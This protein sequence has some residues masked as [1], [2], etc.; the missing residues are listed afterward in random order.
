MFLSGLSNDQLNA[1]GTKIEMRN[2]VSQPKQNTLGTVINGL[3]N[4][5]LARNTQPETLSQEDYT[6]WKSGLNAQDYQTALTPE[7]TK[8]FSDW[9]Y[10][11][12][13]PI[14]NDY[15][16]QGYWK[17]EVA[18]YDALATQGYTPE[19]IAGAKQG[20][21]GGDAILAKFIQEQGIK[22]PTTPSE[23]ALAKQGK[24]N[25]PVYDETTQHYTDKYK[26]P[27]HETFSNESM[28]ATGD[29]AKYAGK[30]EGD[31]F[32]TPYK[33]KVNTVKE[34][35]AQIQ[36][37]YEGN[38]TS[39]GWN[40]V[41]KGADV[42]RAILSNPALQGAVAGLAYGKYKG[43]AMEGLK[44]GVDFASNK[45]TSNYYAKML[46][47]KPGILGNYG[48]N[49]YKAKVTADYNTQRNAIY[50]QNVI[51]QINHRLVQE[52]ISWKELERKLKQDEFD[53]ELAL[54]K[55]G[56]SVAQLQEAIRYHNGMLSQRQNRLKLDKE[57]FEYNK[58]NKGK[59][60][61]SQVALQEK[62]WAIQDSD[63]DEDEKTERINDLINIQALENEGEDPA[64][65]LWD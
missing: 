14:S 7:E 19:Q 49:D 17:N 58:K 16:M 60:P 43:D 31:N 57:K 63:L 37:G 48:V 40:K 53:N 13:A 45:Q 6:T 41:G 30:W 62:I 56:L 52:G 50:E 42:A 1:L 65:D 25:A 61:L 51:S 24:L 3:I 29:N 32:V 55:Y 33:D 10:K 27:L 59:K 4:N 26:T 54:R 47:K 18:P 22:T 20:L 28:Y 11:T 5:T 38:D 46:G 35:L 64:G 44:Y 21:N 15:D 12:N 8:Q 39:S 36:E 34:I 9:A 2:Q 23:I